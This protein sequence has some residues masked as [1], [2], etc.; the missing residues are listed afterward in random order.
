MVDFIK[1]QVYDSEIINN[2]NRNPKLT[3]TQQIE[4]RSGELIEFPKICVYK[5]FKLVIKSPSFLEITGSLHIF[6]T[7]LKNDTDFTLR[8]IKETIQLCENE[9]GINSKYIKLVN[10]EFGVNLQINYPA[11]NFISNAISYKGKRP[12]WHYDAV[13]G[14]NFIEFGKTG[15]YIKLY[16]KGHGKTGQYLLRIE[17]KY[18]RSEFLNPFGIFTLNDLKLEQPFRLLRNEL[19]AITNKLIFDDCSIIATK[20]PPKE[21]E[22]YLILRNP[23]Y[24]SDNYKKRSRQVRYNESRFRKL[25]HKYGSINYNSILNILIEN[26]LDSL[27]NA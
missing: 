13:P 20:L 10:L 2:L 4:L 11:V 24:W 12:K 1:G 17:I 14:F 26:K 18:V 3:F 22:Q 21:R 9:F 5:N 23:N 6:F 16:E 25:I 7:Q 19:L 15:Y 8:Q 27:L